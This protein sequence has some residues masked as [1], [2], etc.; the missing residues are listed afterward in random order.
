MNAGTSMLERIGFVLIAL[1]LGFVQLWLWLAQV[2]LFSA[3]AIVWLVVSIRERAR[4]ET[5]AFFLPLVVYAGL[6]LV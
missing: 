3:A 1:C 4:L 5:P 6:T 2:V